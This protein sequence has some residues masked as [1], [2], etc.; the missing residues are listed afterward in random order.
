MELEIQKYLRDRLWNEVPFVT[1]QEDLKTRFGI[2]TNRHSVFPELIQFSYDQIESPKA[3]PLVRECR[4]IILN[5]ADNWNVVAYPFNRFFN[6]GEQCAD[7]ID[8]STARVQE[9]VDGSLIIMYHYADKWQVGTRGSA[10]ADGQVGDWKKIGTD[11]PWVFRDLFWHSAEYWLK[12]ICKNGN[13][14]VHHTYLFELTS[15]LNRVVC[16]YTKVGIN[17][18][19][20]QATGEILE[21]EADHTGYAQDGSRITLIGSRSNITFRELPVS[22]YE[23]DFHYVVKEFPLTSF[24][25][26]VKA[27]EILNPLDQ[28]GY[29]VVDGNF[30]RVKIKSPKYVALHHLRDGFGTR[31]LMVLIQNGEDG[32]FLSYFPEFT[33]QFTHYK[34]N[35]DNLLAV[36][37]SEWNMVNHLG[38]P[39]VD[40]KTFA[41]EAVKTRVPAFLFMKRKGLADKPVDFLKNMPVDKLLD[42]LK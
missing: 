36:M 1:S 24:D 22:I 2:Y 11:Q 13:L 17:Q 42:L 32:E 27:A 19:I 8:W 7:T 28:E 34:T 10:N 25:E 26:V 29:V 21:Y 6:Y 3:D 40:Q 14:D 33:E 12:G 41:L 4:G 20:C 15:P 37:Q 18:G 30:N 35:Y 39:D 38:G 31:R 9:K 16:D 5:Y 23:N